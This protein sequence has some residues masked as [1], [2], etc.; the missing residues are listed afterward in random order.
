MNRIFQ[1]VSLAVIASPLGLLVCYLLSIGLIDF[2]AEFWSA[3]GAC[4]SAIAASAS[5]LV[6][7][8]VFRSS[9]RSE[10]ESRARE[11]IRLASQ[12]RSYLDIIER[13]FGEARNLAHLRVVQIRKYQEV[14]NAGKAPAESFTVKQAKTLLA[15]DKNH[16]INDLA[17]NAYR[18]NVMDII[19]EVKVIAKDM[20]IFVRLSWIEIWKPFH[21][22]AYE[23][24]KLLEPLSWDAFDGGFD[25]SNKSIPD[26]PDY[27]GYHIFLNGSNP[28]EID[29][30]LSAWKTKEG[31]IRKAKN[32]VSEKLQDIERDVIKI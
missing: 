8:K 30:F 17:L 15:G 20:S 6:A 12:L 10:S 16:R 13:E 25:R 11:V 23:Q 28:Q 26:D 19:Q 7:Y 22:Y 2:N 21:Q 3:I 1:W 4:L 31:N 9:E 27:D 18:E 32:C 24:C 14:A 5:Y 29:G